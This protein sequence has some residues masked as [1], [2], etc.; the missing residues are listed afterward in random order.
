MRLRPGYNER[1]RRFDA[2]LRVRWSSRR[3]VWLL[4]R[5]ARYPRLPVDPARYG[6][7]EHDTVV[8]MRDGYFSLGEYQARDLPSVDHLIAYLRAQDSRRR[9]DQNFEALAEALANDL[10][11]QESARG[12]RVRQSALADVAARSGDLWEHHRWQGQRVAVPGRLR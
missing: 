5:R 7:A 10:D 2:D 12:E 4:E 3:R 1:L 6:Y 9:G 11:A 8:Q